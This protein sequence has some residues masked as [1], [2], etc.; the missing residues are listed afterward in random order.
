MQQTGQTW[1][2]PWRDLDLLMRQRATN[3]RRA[4]GDDM[5]LQSLQPTDHPANHRKISRASRA[6]HA[7]ACGTWPIC[8]DRDAGL[9]RPGWIWPRSRCIS[10]SRLASYGHLVPFVFFFFFIIVI[11]ITT[12]SCS[13]LD[14]VLPR[15]KSLAAVAPAPRTFPTQ[16][17]RCNVGLVCCVMVGLCRS[18]A[19]CPARR[20]A[21]SSRPEP[22]RVAACSCPPC[23]AG[24]RTHTGTEICAVQHEAGTG[25]HRMDDVRGVKVCSHR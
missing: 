16:D 19:D 18:R 8:A 10:S 21:A 4:R 2:A 14:G 1:V 12:G 7:T 3:P 5:F 23:W 25:R 17:R 22:A 24:R 20:A 9:A 15:N 11:I 6:T 13:P